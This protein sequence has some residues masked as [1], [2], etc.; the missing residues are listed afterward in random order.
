MTD[1]DVLSA[2]AE[3]GSSEAFSEIVERYSGPVYSSCLRILRDPHEAEDA[4]Q[5]VFLVFARKARQ[6]A[7][8]DSLPG[9]LIRT[10]EYVSRN[11]RRARWRR[12]KHERATEPPAPALPRGPGEGASEWEALR[13]HLDA[14]LAELPPAQRDALILR[15]LR[16]LDRTAIARELG[17][18]ERT[19]NTWLTRGLTRLRK[20]LARH[21]V[22]VTALL[23]AALLSERTASAA[24]ADLAAGILSADPSAADPGFLALEG[25]I[26]TAIGP[27][28]AAA[29]PLA[30]KAG[31]VAAAVLGLAVS[32]PRLLPPSAPPAP[33][34][35]P[36]PRGAGAALAEWLAVPEPIWLPVSLTFDGSA[37]WFANNDT[38]GGAAETRIYRVDPRDGRLLSS[39]DLRTRLTQPW[40]LAWDGSRVWAAD[41]VGRVAAAD[42]ATGRVT[43][44]FR[45]AAPPSADPVPV[46][47][48]VPAGNISLPA[49]SVTDLCAGAGSLWSLGATPRGSTTTIQRID[50][51][52]GKAGAAFEA[53]SAA[54]SIAFSDGALW[55]LISGRP[56]R[57]QKRDPSTGAVLASMELPVLPA[58]SIESDGQGGLWVLTG[59]KAVRIPLPAR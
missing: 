23:L 53:P 19:V 4:A 15:Y 20:N 49:A 28:P 14:A 31:A 50:P 47:N 27:P 33:P 51:A 18:A 32:V 46:P 10:A 55:V 30:W 6:R 17:C 42:P 16:G 40:G 11:A 3:S 59:R 29:I 45:L 13:P 5:E 41:L 52:D 58:Q 57:L 8:P 38:H 2:Y 1:Q 48:I 7:V 22:T 37:L 26:S 25:E 36:A 43:R 24:P 34:P 39:V 35:A 56:A 54:A 44:S 21:G 12:S 9:W